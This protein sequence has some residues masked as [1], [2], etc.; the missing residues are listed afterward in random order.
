[1]KDLFTFAIAAMFVAAPMTA[2]AQEEVEEIDLTPDLFMSWADPENPNANCGCEY[3][4]GEMTGMPIG[5]GNVDPVIY[6]DI[7]EYDVLTVYVSEK[8]ADAAFPRPFLNRMAADQQA[9][10]EFDASLPVDFNKQWARD[11][12][13][14]ESG[15]ADNGWEYTFD[16]KKIVEDYGLAYL[17][18]IK[19]GNWSQLVVDAMV[20]SKGG[21]VGITTITLKDAIESKAVN[22]AGQPVGK[23]YKGV[24]IKNG[25]KFVQ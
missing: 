19:V 5:N 13:M 22:L 16:I 9:G 7:S 3:N 18:C 17:H 6:A 4:I 25:K 11:R 15:D 1:M 2:N 23:N 10:E 8:A 12:Y 21:T 14:T 24:V 20:L